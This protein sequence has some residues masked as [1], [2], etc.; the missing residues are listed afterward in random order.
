MDES[1][2]HLHFR[3][4]KVLVAKGDESVLQVKV[5]AQKTLRWLP[6]AVQRDISFRM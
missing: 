3:P 6:A 2:L 4:G 5:N 1:G